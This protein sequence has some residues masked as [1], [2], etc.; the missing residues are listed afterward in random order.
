MPKQL[1]TKRM[2]DNMKWIR[3]REP[4]SRGKTM[5]AGA[6]VN[7]HGINVT[8]STWRACECYDADAPHSVNGSTLGEI[9]RALVLEPPKGAW[10]GDLDRDPLIFPEFY[11][12]HVAKLIV[13]VEK[14]NRPPWHK[15]RWRVAGL[16]VAIVVALAIAAA[17]I[18]W[19]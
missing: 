15:R 11:D 9:C 1:I 5:G 6:F 13:T 12:E 14:R 19:G 7:A 2:A 3:E 4:M 16:V 17:R 8:G 10:G 18:L